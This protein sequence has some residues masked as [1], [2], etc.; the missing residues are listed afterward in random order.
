MDD[1]SLTV[2]SVDLEQL[3]QFVK[4]LSK[5]EPP[6]PCYL[7]LVGTLGAGKTCLAKLLVQAWCG[8]SVEVTSPTFTLAQHYCGMIGDRS[9]RVNHLDL[10][11]VGDEDELWELGFDELLEQRDSITLVEWADR[12]IDAMPSETI[13]IELEPFDSAPNA[14]RKLLMHCRESL[15]FN[16][17]ARALQE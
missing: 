7:A 4:R 13:W 17:M 9:F 1:H 8:D 2:A 5:D 15:R 12:F 10:Y 14:P 11:R 3:S 16:W 6:L